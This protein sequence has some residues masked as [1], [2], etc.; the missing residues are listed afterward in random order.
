MHWQALLG[1]S[2][3]LSIVVLDIDCWLG[4]QATVAP[5]ALQAGLLV[6]R[7]VRHAF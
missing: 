6:H 1:H 7:H 2:G 3:I 4:E 5:A